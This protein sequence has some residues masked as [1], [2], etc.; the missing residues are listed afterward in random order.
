MLLNASFNY[1]YFEFKKR[2][3]GLVFHGGFYKKDILY[4]HSVSLY[5]PS[6]IAQLVKKPPATQETLVGFLIWED[7]LEKR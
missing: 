5:R 1:T 2:I 6:L 3:F 7:P 4:F